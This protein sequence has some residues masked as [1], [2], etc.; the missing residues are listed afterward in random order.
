MTTDSRCLTAFY[1]ETF[2]RDNRA[3]AMASADPFG[4]GSLMLP[5]RSSQCE[6]GK[7]TFASGKGGG[8]EPRGDLLVLA[9]TLSL[10]D[11]ATAATVNAGE[12]VGIALGISV[13]DNKA[14]LAPSNPP[15]AELLLGEYRC[16]ARA[17]CSS[18]PTSP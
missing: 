4:T 13:I 8:A 17:R 2:S 18:P 9:S 14:P 5:V 11:G 15:S 7:V 16:A 1:V 12:S 3:A 10:S 6:V